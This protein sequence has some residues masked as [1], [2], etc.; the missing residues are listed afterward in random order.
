MRTNLFN[1]I[2][3]EDNENLEQR[4]QPDSY[5][6]QQCFH[7]D[8][9]LS[10]EMKSFSILAQERKQML[11]KNTLLQQTNT[12]VWR[13][14]LVT[15]QEANILKNE[16]TIRKEELIAIINSVLISLPDSQRT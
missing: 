10:E 11:I 14:I 7:G 9:N 3:Y 2:G 8:V 15:E 13:P 6:E 12:N 1:V 5:I 16:N 4:T